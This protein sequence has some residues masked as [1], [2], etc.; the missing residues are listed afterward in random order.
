MSVVGAKTYSLI[1]NLAS[2][3]KPGE[4]SYAELRTLVKNHLQPKPLVI[5]ERFKFHQHKQGEG[6]SVSQYLAELHKLSENCEFKEF[7]VFPAARKKGR[8]L[9]SWKRALTTRENPFKGHP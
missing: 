7:L 3:D 5:A 1:R 4:K 2:P 6:E 8:V 9:A